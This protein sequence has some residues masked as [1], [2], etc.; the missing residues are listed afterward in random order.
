MS[1]LS[2]QIVIVEARQELEH[3]LVKG[4]VDVRCNFLVREN[5]RSINASAFD[6][7]VGPPRFPI[8]LA[9]PEIDETKR[10]LHARRFED[11]TDPFGPFF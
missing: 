7:L 8:A 4:L 2:V 6:G 3:V 1:L 5:V 9:P 11:L 10:R